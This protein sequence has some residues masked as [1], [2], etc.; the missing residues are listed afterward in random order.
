MGGERRPVASER[1]T[2]SDGLPRGTAHALRYHLPCRRRAPCRKDQPEMDADVRDES[3]GSDER[4]TFNVFGLKLEVSNPRLAEL[5]A[6]DAREAL[7][8]DVRELAS[9]R[10]VRELRDEAAQ[11]LPD[12]VMSPPT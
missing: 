4:Y 1:S 12:V 3:D 9:P 5:L 8:T 6:M 2:I 11:A 7:T 10:A